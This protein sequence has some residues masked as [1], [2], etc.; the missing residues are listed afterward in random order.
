M[1]DKIIE[2]FNEVFVQIFLIIIK[3][4]NIIINAN[5]NIFKNI[6]DDK[7]ENEQLFSYEL[8]IE[9]DFIDDELKHYLLGHQNNEPCILF[10]KDICVK[11]YSPGTFNLNDI[12]PISYFMNNNTNF[13][14]WLKTTLDDE[15]LVIRKRYNKLTKKY[16]ND[17][18]Y[19]R[20]KKLLNKNTRTGYPLKKEIWYQEYSD[21]FRRL[22]LFVTNNNSNLQLELYPNLTYKRK[23]IVLKIIKWIEQNKREIKLKDWLY[24][25]IAAGLLG[26]DNKS[27]HSASSEINKN[28]V[29][30]FNDEGEK[31]KDKIKRIGEELWKLAHS[32]NRIDASEWLF[33]Y[34]DSSSGINVNVVVFPDDYI[35]SIFLLKFHNEL[36][37]IYQNIKIICV[38]R[39]VRCGND[40]KYDDMLLL[41]NSFP[42][43]KNNKNYII[44]K[45]G[46]ILGTVNLLKLHPSIISLIENCDFIDARGARNY[47]MMQG[48][49]RDCFFG[50]MVCREFSEATTGLFAEDKPLIFMRQILGEYSFK[51]FMRRNERVEK[52]RKLCLITAKDNKEKWQGGILANFDK[53]DNEWKN[54]Y[55][56]NLS[57]YTNNA[58][59]FHSKFGELL[60]NDVKEYLNKF[61][62]KVLVLGCGSGK[63]VNYL[64]NKNCDVTGIDFSVQAIHL[65]KK[66]YP[67][68]WNR[69][70]VDDYYNI[71]H[72]QSGYYNGIV[73]NASFVHLSEKN[74]LAT[75]VKKIKNRL[76][77]GGLGFIR[78][79]EKENKDFEYDKKFSDRVRF[80]TYFSLEYIEKICEQENLKIIKNNSKIPHAHYADDGVYWNSV[81]FE[82]K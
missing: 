32:E 54:R 64:Y 30:S 63:E 72:F 82:K 76:C 33:K 65:A 67:H 66:L 3:N 25:S 19:N 4:V 20:I 26:V 81:L 6:A 13:D 36:M 56:T 75:M 68:L 9:D 29:I 16:S 58:S 60:E 53:W 69:F 11:D 5:K 37:K 57:F 31:T 34:L 41:L 79:L 49:K 14:D 7:R 23:N 71:E 73:A 46:P 42:R 38:P 40:L 10:R 62:N 51:D 27:K 43:L 8:S 12:N 80:F 21:V 24:I 47:E 70:F 39:S 17:E 59:S 1:R 48:I 18:I 45:N 77:I 50:F 74:D 15:L 52:G 28:I 61:E 22:I 2:I 44:A 78:V 35:E 55:E